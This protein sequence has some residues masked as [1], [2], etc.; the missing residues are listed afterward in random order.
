MS[1]GTLSIACLPGYETIGL[2]AP[3]VMVIG[4]LIQGFS[5]GVELGGVSVYLSEIATR[6][7]KGF[8][9]SW[10][11]ASQQMAVVFAALLG[12][13]LNSALSTPDME[14]WGWRV[15]LLIGCTIIPFFFMIRR[16]LQ[17]TDEFQARKRHPTA[18]EVVR[19]V[20]VNWRVVLTGMML[21]TMT[22]AWFYFITA[23]TPT[24]GTKVLLLG[25]TDTFVVTLCMGVSNLFWLPVMGGLSDRIGRRPL[26]VACTILALATAFPALAWLVSSPSLPRMLAVYLWFSLLYAGYN[27]AMIVF[28]TEI[29]P[30]AGRASGFSLAYS[31][32]TA[33]FG[34]FTPLV[35]EFLIEHTGNQALPGLWLAL[36]A[37]CGL[38][39]ALV[40]GRAARASPD[41]SPRNALS[42]SNESPGK[43]PR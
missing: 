1:I 13:V 28:L 11:S 23:Y 27:G 29:M 40:A 3:V 17:E 2:F 22:T 4:R 36:A 6:G 9:V 43:L 16:S 42:E 18:S 12:V 33:L 8:Y 35:C 26:L 21:V 31:L 7:H 14:R 34:G 25:S 19:A 39:A 24:Y 20:A 38:V 41:H 10:Q 30:V 5:A 37:A 32:A 15:P